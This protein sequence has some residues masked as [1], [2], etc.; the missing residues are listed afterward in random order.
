MSSSNKVTLIEKV[1]NFSGK[2][3]K[4]ILFGTVVVITVGAGVVYLNKSNTKSTKKSKK[5]SEKLS[6][7]ND[8]PRDTQNLSETEIKELARTAKNM[9]NKLFGENKFD[10]AIQLY[11][12]AIQL[13]P[14]AVYF[15]NRAACE[16]RL[17]NWSKVI[18]DCTEALNRDPMYIKALL[19]RA[20]A[21]EH[22]NEFKESL[23]DYSALC[24]LEE[25]KNTTSMASADRVLKNLGTKIA[26]ELIKDK[27]ERLPS[28]TFISASSELAD[29]LTIPEVSEA[30]GIFKKAIMNIMKQKY[31]E[32]KSN[33][34]K[35]IELGNLSKDFEAFAYNLRGTFLFL[36]GNVDKAMVAFEKSIELDP[37]QVDSYIKKACLYMEKGDTETCQKEFEAAS[38]IKDDNVDFYYHRGQI[39]HLIG[40]L[41]DAMA[42][43]SKSLLYDP[44]LVYAKIQ[45]GVTQYKSGQIQAAN[46]TFKEAEILFSNRSEVFN[47]QGEIYLDQGDDVKALESFDKAIQL[48][49]NSSLP[50]INKA[51]LYLQARND[52]AT[53]EKL[54]KKAIEIDPYGDVA[55]GPLA[56]LYLTQNRVAEARE[57]YDKSIAAARTENELVTAVCSRE[58]ALAQ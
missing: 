35:S 18:S 2:Y 57:V 47:Y 38:K 29:F 1:T 44:N 46:E 4:E 26:A 28:D 52:A 11:T 34:D 43:F 14:E 32:A 9:G 5:P 48:N 22:K 49:P 54:L 31:E 45:L 56:Q 15:N 7:T 51:L 10:E 37:T 25:F 36:V 16:A 17:K 20:T 39:K 41:A 6:A 19:R 13:S 40:E 30:D 33:V 55:F 42:D 21:Y 50:Y 8:K 58:A 27:V 12:E 53:A 23:N 24:V 3:W